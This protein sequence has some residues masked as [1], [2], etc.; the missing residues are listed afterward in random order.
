MREGG[1]VVGADTGRPSREIEAGA[2][3][4]RGLHPVDALETVRP[5]ELSVAYSGDV[6][7][8]YLAAGRLMGI[9]GE[10]RRRVAELIGLDL[11][12]VEMPFSEMLAATEQGRIDT[13]GIG[14]LMT[15]G[16]SRRFLF[17]QP[18]QY[19][20]L[21][22]AKRHCPPL[23]DIHAIQDLRVTALAAS[24]NND[25]LAALVNGAGGRFE[26]SP[27]LVAILDALAAERFDVAVYDRPNIEIGLGSRPELSGFSVGGFRFDRRYPHTT[28]PMPLRLLFRGDAHHLVAA[29]G[30]AIDLL[31]KT[32]ELIRIYDR[33]GFA[34]KQLSSLIA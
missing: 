32:G 8:D 12:L 1:A 20:R 16:R 5:G 15:L 27:S 2:E 17:T 21:G 13:P 9:H 24:A 6:P 28:G 10:V 34:G 22:V 18:F 31:A 33:Y 7:T 30:L 11:H 4:L 19:F 3:I 14:T 25:E 23:V 26:E 29:A